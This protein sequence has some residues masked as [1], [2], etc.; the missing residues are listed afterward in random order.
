MASFRADFEGKK[1]GK[2][3]NQGLTPSS[4]ETWKHYRLKEILKHSMDLCLP[5]KSPDLVI[6]AHNHEFRSMRRAICVTVFL[7]FVLACVRPVE[8]SKPIELT[9]FYAQLTDGDLIEIPLTVPGFKKRYLFGASLRK[10]LFKLKEKLDWAPDHVFCDLEGVLVHKWGDWQGLEQ[11]FQE[12]AGSF[13]LR[14]DFADNWINL[15]SISLVNGLSLTTE[16]PEYEE[17]TTLNGQTS[18]LLY[19]LMLDVAFDLPCTAKWQLVFRVHHRSGVFGLID[20]VDGGSNYL[21]IGLRYP[22]NIF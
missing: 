9:L 8:G 20:N 15:D 12:L 22:L 13:N 16:E 7:T 2:L 19:Y 10:E 21:G 14:Y 18:N 6:S 1:A 11:S 5:V 4:P 3:K 17:E